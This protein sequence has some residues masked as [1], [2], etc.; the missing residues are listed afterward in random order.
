MRNTTVFA[1]K[2]FKISVVHSLACHAEASSR[3]VLSR[4]SFS[5][6]GRLAKA[7]EASIAFAFRYSLTTSICLSISCPVNRSIAPCTAR[8]ELSPG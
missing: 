7:G 4:R 2:C 3:A 6:D 1:F 8:S 5:E